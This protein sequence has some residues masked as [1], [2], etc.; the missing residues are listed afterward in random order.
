M[1]GLEPDRD[2]I[3]EIAIVLTDEA[4][5]REV[6][7]EAPVIAVHQP[8]SV[9]RR[10]GRVEPQYP[11]QVRAHRPGTRL[12]DVRPRPDAAER[13]CWRLPCASTVPV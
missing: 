1:T 5:T 8:D 2:R 4:L 9:P 3:I 12:H 10:H 6:I 7:A 11:R 13:R